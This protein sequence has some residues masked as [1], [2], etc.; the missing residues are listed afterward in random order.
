MFQRRYSC[1]CYDQCLHAP[2]WSTC[3]NFI[4]YVPLEMKGQSESSACCRLQPCMRMSIYEATKYELFVCDRV[5]FF[6]FFCK[7]RHQISINSF[8]RCSQQWA[9]QLFSF[10]TRQV[11]CSTVWHALYIRSLSAASVKLNV[12]E[13]RSFNH[14]PCIANCCSLTFK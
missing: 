6:C 14:L 11:L 3:A 7:F 10:L 2:Y 9:S 4:T 13:D 5:A 12:H 8:Y 1:D